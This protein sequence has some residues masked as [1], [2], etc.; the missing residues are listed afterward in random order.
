MAVPGSMTITQVIY[1]RRWI[2]EKVRFSQSHSCSS[3]YYATGL[4]QIVD[5]RDLI[6]S[7]RSSYLKFT[8]QYQ[9]TEN[10]LL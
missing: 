2:M 4:V 6:Q 3:S 7:F 8:R 5:V 1:Q 9:T 10:L